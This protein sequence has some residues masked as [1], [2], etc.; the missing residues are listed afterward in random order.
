MAIITVTGKHGINSLSA[1]PG[2]EFNLSLATLAL[3]VV[4]FGSG[5]YSVD[6]LVAVAWVWPR[7]D[8]DPSMGISSRPRGSQLPELSQTS[9][10]PSHRTF[11]IAF[12]WVRLVRISANVVG[13]LAPLSLRERATCI[14]WTRIP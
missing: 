2:Y 1:T 14:I 13:P 7:R 4:A 8:T 3:I 9:V 6:A 12:Q 5:P 10:P 11:P